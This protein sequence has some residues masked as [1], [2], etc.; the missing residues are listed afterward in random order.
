MFLEGI[1]GVW[2]DLFLVPISGYTSMILLD[3]DFLGG[4]ISNLSIHILSLGYLFLLLCTI[5]ESFKNCLILIQKKVII[6]QGL[7]NFQRWP[8]VFSFIWFLGM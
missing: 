8:A 2:I 3:T 5:T 6:L 4:R 7:A 1:R